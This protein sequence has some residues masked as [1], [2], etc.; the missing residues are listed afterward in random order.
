MQLI[1]EGLEW[2]VI[3]TYRCYDQGAPKPHTICSNVAGIYATDADTALTLH[4]V[5]AIVNLMVIRITHKPFR[6][7]HI[8]PVSSSILQY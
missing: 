8:H 5:Q 3:D 6:E 2:T 1:S 7:C 4:E